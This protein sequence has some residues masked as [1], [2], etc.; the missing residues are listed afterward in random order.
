M[1]YAPALRARG[2]ML[3]Y[4]GDARLAPLLEPTRLFE[5]VTS[6]ADAPPAADRV[7]LV[8]D[9][10]E[11]LGDDEAAPRPPSL[12]FPV[13]AGW[14]AAPVGARRGRPAAVRRRDLAGGAGREPVGS[15]EPG[16]LLQTSRAGAA[17]GRAARPGPGPSR[18][19]S[20]MLSRRTARRSAARSARRTG[21]HR[22]RR[23]SRRPARAHGAR[24]RVRRREQHRHAPARR[25][26]THPRVLAPLPVEWRWGAAGDGSPWFHGFPRSIVET[27]RGRRA[28][29]P[30]SARLGSESPLHP[31]PA[32]EEEI[33]EE[34][35][36][37]TA[38][39]GLLNA[40]SSTAR[41]STTRCSSSC[42]RS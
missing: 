38:Q 35:M 9:L 7:A 3:F 10:P 34:K 17:R 23:R 31:R 13:V 2:A 33:E 16:G 1:R 37:I 6:R 24:R 20:G 26:R 15:V 28:G 32:V 29:P 40:P 27:W 30:R 39:E 21:P 14:R 36:A 42:A 19:C 25:G 22:A 41:S 18:S 8:G 12:R 11:I 4:H 5:A